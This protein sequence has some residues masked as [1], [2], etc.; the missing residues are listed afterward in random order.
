MSNKSFIV[1]HDFSEVADNALSH[2]IT[3]AKVVDAKIYLL[4]VISK[5]KDIKEAE[6]NLTA[7]YL[8]ILH[9]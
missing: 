8:Q 6:A 1:P 5:N 7:V 4:H 9:S 3:T 2:A